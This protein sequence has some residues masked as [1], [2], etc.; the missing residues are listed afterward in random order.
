MALEP[1]IQPDAVA[2]AP[3]VKQP[4][5]LFRW[6]LQYYRLVTIVACLAILLLGYFLFISPKI[7]KVRKMEVTKLAEEREKRQNLER[8]LQYL[9]AL[10]A[11]RAEISQADIEKVAAMLPADLAVPEL[12]AAIEGIAKASQVTVEG[13][14]IALLDQPKA[15]GKESKAKDEP[16]AV[17]LPAGVKGLEVSLTIVGTPY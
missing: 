17:N 6:F 3:T 14:D 15:K 11:K 16:G 8:K 9:A 13:I 5:Y 2:S 7:G 10:S 4:S 1:K 12:F